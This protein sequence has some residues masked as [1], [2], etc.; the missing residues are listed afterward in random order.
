[1]E[2]SFE[3]CQIKNWLS[4]VFECIVLIVVSQSD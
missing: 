1:M 2:N 3:S 4:F